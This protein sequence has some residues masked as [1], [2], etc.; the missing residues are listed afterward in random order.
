MRVIIAGSRTI[1]D[2][3]PVQDAIRQSGFDITEVIS[4]DLLDWVWAKER[5]IP[6]KAMPAD[7]KRYGIMAGFKR[8]RA[9]AA[10]ADALIAVW[11][12]KSRGTA[13][14]VKVAR[15]YALKIFLYVVEGA[16]A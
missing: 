4:P 15:G 9:M 12:G 13:D 11:D 16:A 3:K 10:N 14:M 7:W 1:L 5:R 2:P 8:N 6:I